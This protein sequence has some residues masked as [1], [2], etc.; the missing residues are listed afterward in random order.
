MSYV[1]KGAT[2]SLVAQEPYFDAS[3]GESGAEVTYSGTQG[4]I[5]GLTPGYKAQGISF[6]ISQ[7]GPVHIIT[8]RIPDSIVS[9]L[10]PDRYEITTTSQDKD[11]FE[12]PDVIAEMNAF[13]STLT[14]GQKT[15]RKLAEENVDKNFA[16]DVVDGT[17]PLYDNVIRHLKAGVTGFQIDFLTIRRFRVLSIEYAGGAGAFSLSAGSYI[18]TTAQL[19]LPDG[20]AFTLPATPTAPSSDF[21]WGWRN[22]GQR[23]EIVGSNAEQTIELV[24]APWSTL[25][26]APSVGNLSW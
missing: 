16:T 13:D 11:I 3:S 9:D 19:Q 15:Y 2:L 17:Y 20:V 4:A 6:R 23:V 12:H 7:S 26:Y 10:P 18:Y 25:A 5:Y 14:E 22:T 24:F 8:A 1:W 21:A